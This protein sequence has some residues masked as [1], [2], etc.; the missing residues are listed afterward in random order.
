[1]PTPF[2][3][4]FETSWSEADEAFVS[5]VPALRYCAAHGE[6]AEAAVRQALVAAEAVLSVMRE[7]GV[8]LPDTDI[9][10]AEA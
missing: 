7:D 8:P 3:Y 9:Q 5:R 10:A 1:M 4:R 6:T 2:P